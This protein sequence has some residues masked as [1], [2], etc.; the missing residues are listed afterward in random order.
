MHGVKDRPRVIGTGI[1]TWTHTELHTH[2]HT[3]THTQ[4]HPDSMQ[5]CRARVKLLLGIKT[6]GV[7]VTL[8][9]E[10]RALL[11]IKIGV[12]SVKFFPLPMPAP[13]G[14]IKKTPP[15]PPQTQGHHVFLRILGS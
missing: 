12:P 15:T 7:H 9:V 11:E 1:D 2:T 14:I 10:L 8:S 6:L 5:E 4:G 13:R 3:H